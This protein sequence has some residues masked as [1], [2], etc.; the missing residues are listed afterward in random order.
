MASTPP[1]ANP[2][3]PLHYPATTGRVGHRLHAGLI[4]LV[5]VVV[6]VLA[7]A[8]T[9]AFG[10]TRGPA[11]STPPP[12]GTA[13]THHAGFSGHTAREPLIRLAGYASTAPA[14]LQTRPAT[15]PI[16]VPLSTPPVTIGSGITITVAPGWTISSQQAGNV[17]LLN[18]DSSVSLFVAIGKGPITDVTQ[19]LNA[20][21]AENSTGANAIYSNVQLAGGV[22]TYTLQ[23]ANF[24]Q[25]AAVAYTADESTQQGTL[26]TTGVFREWLNTSTGLSAFIDLNAVSDE[27]LQA[28]L[29]DYQNM[30]SSML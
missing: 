25:E 4:A 24:Q 27:T 1:G 6:I 21:I 29:T 7:T 16:P 10:Y 20:D 14:S 28:A 8:T 13:V 2:P 30:N 11:T 12:A 19:E 5:I 17:S 22:K 26:H 18:A 9:M 15:I 3:P 23:S